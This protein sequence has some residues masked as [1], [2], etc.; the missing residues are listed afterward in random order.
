MGNQRVSRKANGD[1]TEESRMAGQKA[2]S[3]FPL[4]KLANEWI[5]VEL[6]NSF[7]K[8]VSE[9]GRSGSRGHLQEI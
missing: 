7:I 9:N 4:A 8:E 2:Q 1:I 6:G 3:V 5:G